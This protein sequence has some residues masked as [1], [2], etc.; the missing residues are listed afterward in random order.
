MAKQNIR[1]IKPMITGCIGGL[2]GVLMVGLLHAVMNRYA[3]TGW[4]VNLIGVDGTIRYSLDM[5]V[6]FVTAFLFSGILYGWKGKTGRGDRM[7]SE[8]LQETGKLQ[9]AG[10]GVIYSPLRGQVI[11]MEEVPDD[12]FAAK[13]LG[14]GVAVIPVE[15]M[16]YAPFDGRVEKVYEARHAIGI[17]SA[18]GIEVLIH[19]GINTGESDEGFFQTFVVN[20]D[21]FHRG[22]P[23]LR[24]KI[25]EMKEAGYST[26][27]PIIVTNSDDYDVI[28]MLGNG[29]VDPQDILMR[30]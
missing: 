20:G 23:L 24:F 9:T 30:V 6:A 18:D 19:V 8:K 10:D 1:Y 25:A 16:V 13:V 7:V 21:W 12:T 5:A 4:L 2:A 29:M 22:D 15:G 17:S 26:V 27:T 14:D 11:P 28:Q 3:N